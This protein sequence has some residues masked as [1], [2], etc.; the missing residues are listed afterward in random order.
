MI[1]DGC[2][3]CNSRAGFVPTDKSPMALGAFTKQSR[4]LRQITNKEKFRTSYENW[5]CNIQ[6]INKIHKQSKVRDYKIL[7]WM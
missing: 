6:E 5:V 3:Y 4:C 1:C 2:C 7:F